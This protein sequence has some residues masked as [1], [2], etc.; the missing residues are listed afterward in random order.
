MPGGLVE[1]RELALALGV[2]IRAQFR[3]Q[4]LDLLDLRELHPEFMSELR[5][6]QIADRRPHVLRMHEQLLALAV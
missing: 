3:M 6:D 2:G 5:T 1:H 4:A